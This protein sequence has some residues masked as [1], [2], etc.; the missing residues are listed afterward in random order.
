MVESTIGFLVKTS[1]DITKIEV[2]MGYM[3]MEINLEICLKLKNNR[4]R[5]FLQYQQISQV[6][7]WKITFCSQCMFL[8]F[9]LFIFH[10]FFCICFFNYVVCLS[11]P[12]FSMLFFYFPRQIKDSTSYSPQ[13][14]EF[15]T[16]SDSSG[17]FPMFSR[18]PKPFLAKSAF[19]S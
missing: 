8:F 17:G 7:P 3:I 16:W 12:G 4:K 1:M 14:T 13:T 18:F 5:E 10:V 6:L 2:W 19:C 11:L 15:R 9:V